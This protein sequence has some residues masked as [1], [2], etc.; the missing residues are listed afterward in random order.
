MLLT[1]VMIHDSGAQSRKPTTGNTRSRERERS[2]SPVD[3]SVSSSSRI[4][5]RVEADGRPVTDATI[6]ALPVNLNDLEGAVTSLFTPT[7]V[8]AD[9]S[10]EVTG[11]RPGAYR[12]SANSPGYVSDPESKEFYRPGDSVILSLVKGGVITG[13]VTNYYGDAVVGAVVRAI[14]VREKD[15]KP[16]RATSYITSQISG[17]I[18]ELLGPFTTDDRGIYRIFGLAPGYYQVSA[19][20]RGS[21]GFSLTVGNAF[22]SDAPT[23]YPSSTIDT[24]VDVLVLAGQEANS[25][26]IR[27]RGNRGHS[28]S[29]SV[30]VPAGP[31]TQGISVSVT[32][33][34]N[35]VAVASIP[36]IEVRNQN[37]FAVEAL[38]D[39]EYIVMA[40]GTSGNPLIRSGN[41]SFSASASRRVTVRGADVTGL[42]LVLEP[43][44]S[45][46][47]RVLVEPPQP[48]KQK[49]ECKDGRHARLE[50]TVLTTLDD[51]KETS[52]D[53]LSTSFA[54]F[55][56]TTPDA[57]GEFAVS[58]LRP[59]NHR[60]GIELPGEQFY[61]KS[62]VVPQSD[63]RP[64]DIARDGIRVKS[65]DNIKGLLVTLGEDAA[66]L[67]GKVVTTDDKLLAQLRIH[68]VPAEP[69]AANDVL[70]YNEVAVGAEG[71][72]SM[73]NLAPG[74]YWVVARD[75]S[76][77][78]ST[79]ERK[80]LAWDAG[81][82]LALR[83]EGEATKKTV[84]L[85]PCQRMI[86]FVFS[87]APL[88]TPSRQP[89]KRPN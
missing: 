5:G 30:S 62:A 47:G 66:A 27:Y 24:A 46:A 21:L 9:G 33:A 15:E 54:E 22:E 6:V 55:K 23:Y 18:S 83:F 74:K 20:G 12:L 82:R 70:R 71:K 63:A 39:G 75:T 59:G 8:E 85:N 13:R 3:K 7:I 50:G 1:S 36:V 57:N 49:V 35:G 77:G 58:L 37:R 87:H 48:G 80:P 64:T 44:G 52:V 69:E 42:D 17:S 84:Q 38:H 45:I 26:D 2:I 4:K 61:I 72:F 53:P 81:E 25:I 43:L 88:V 11:L 51:R 10:F 16:A 19:G 56:K 32:R 34:S 67:N 86:D 29:G 68:L 78:I 73:T 89:L 41:T 65:G 40:T 14:K 31:K 60:L 28:I 76:G 79:G